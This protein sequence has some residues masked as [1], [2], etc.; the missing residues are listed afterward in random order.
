ML[1]GGAAAT[2]VGAITAVPAVWSGGGN[3]AAASE[4]EDIADQMAKA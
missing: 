3:Q 1:K 2:A 4:I